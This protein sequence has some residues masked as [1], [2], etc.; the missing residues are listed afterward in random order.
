MVQIGKQN[1][2]K[3]IKEV[4]F[5]VYL[6]GG[7]LGNILLPDR[8]VPN[9]CEAGDLIKVFLYFDSEDRLIATTEKPYA[10][11]EENAC[12]KVI[13]VNT[14][15]AFLDWG[16]PKDLRVPFSQQHTRM[17]TGTSHIVH[18]YLDESGRIAASAKLDRFL[19]KKPVHYHIGQSVNL[20][21]S[22][23]T[24]LGY[25]AIVNDAHWG[26]LYADDLF[27]PLKKGRRIKGYIKKIR[28][29]Q[30][31]DLTLQKQ[32]YER[33]EDATE[34]ILKAIKADNGF[35]ALTDKSPPDLI[36]KRFGI[37]KKTF[38]KAVGALY[39]KK[40]IIIEPAGLRLRGD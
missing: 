10:M 22:G 26:V 32:G 16:L 8:Y 28:G 23:P 5:G 7:A 20:L 2:L 34:S 3:V 14:Q 39:K 1:C 33:V 35:I 29:D 30:K 9:H 13:A 6:D 36:A 24:D 27:R 31:I 4:D 25:K 19:N 38:K 18:L 21:I 17:K 11:L 40:V 12:L 15:G 37:S